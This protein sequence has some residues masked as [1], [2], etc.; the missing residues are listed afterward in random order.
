MQNVDVVRSLW[1]VMVDGLEWMGLP[2]QAPSPAH[3]AAASA[4]DNER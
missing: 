3:S 4:D 1:C 2:V